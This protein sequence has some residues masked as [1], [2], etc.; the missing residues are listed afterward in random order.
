MSKTVKTITAVLTAL[1]ITVLLCGAAIWLIRRE[2][3][4][5]YVGYK[6]KK[7][8]ASDKNNSLGCLTIGEHTFTVGSLTGEKSDYEVKITPN[9]NK[10]FE[11]MTDGSV[12]LWKNNDTDFKEYFGFKKT[13]GG[14]TLETTAELTILSI[15]E[16][17]YGEAEILGDYKRIADYF[18][19]TAMCENT[20]VT[21]TLGIPL[22]PP[23]PAENITVEPEQIIF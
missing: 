9:P 20:A 5:V 16:N 6:D 14:F 4:D 1:L 18:L 2:G 11:Y 19:L 22:F 8:L 21:V 10:P 3:L 7:Y 13:D 15:L 23:K 17:S 12:R